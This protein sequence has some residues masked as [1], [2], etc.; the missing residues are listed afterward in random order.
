MGNPRVR[1]YHLIITTYGFWLPNDPRGSW[2][3][4][5]RSFELALLGHAT[6]TNER[7]SLAY[8]EHDRALRRRQKDALVRDPVRFNGLQ[9]R[10]IARGVAWS[11]ERSAF[12]IHACAIMPDHAHF[13]I[14]RHRYAIEL[15]AAQLKSNATRQLASEQL[16]PFQHD[17]YQIGRAHV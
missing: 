7:R 10:A 5:V 4:F 1:A 17:L 11:V 6:K 15:V 2:S 3:D 16:H 9:A 8:D 13:V 12:V 14:A